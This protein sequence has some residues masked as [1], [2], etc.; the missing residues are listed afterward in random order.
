V[1]SPLAL[2]GAIV[3]ALVVLQPQAASAAWAAAG[4][5]NGPA[6]ATFVHR[7]EAPTATRVGSSVR[8]DWSAVTL[9]EGT[10]VT[11]YTVLRHTGQGGVTEI[12]TTTE[13]TRSC[14]DSAP[15]QGAV[16]YG[17]VARFRSWAGQESP[18]TPFTFDQTPPVT[19]LTSAPAPNA[20]GWNNTAVTITLTATDAASAVASITYRIGT[21]SPVTVTG[22][23][24]SFPVSIE[25][26]TPVTYYATDTAGNVEAARSYTVKIDTAPPPAPTFTAISN[27]SGVLS[28]R[29]TNVAAQTLSGTAE[30]GT[31]V[32]IRR[33]ATTFPTTI[34]AGN[35]TYSVPVT[36]V[37]GVNAFTATAT[38]QAGNNSSAS[39]PFNVTLD[40]VL[41]TLTIT[42]PKNGVAYRNNTGPAAN[43]WANTCS[44]YPGACGTATDTGPGVTSVTLT[45]RD[46]VAN[47]CWSGTGTTYATCGSQLGVTTVGTS[48]W[49]RSITYS[50]VTGRSLQ[51]TI[52]VTD[53]AGNFTSGTVNFTAQ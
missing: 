32:T 53:L 5:G 44:G 9:D 8:L 15:V 36:L 35:G 14:T 25:G 4:T 27:D 41:P 23:S 31:I 40:T 22:S 45:L 16:Q 48:Q 38:D 17:V 24:T 20:A 37:E 19:S 46:T 50:V 21:G 6:A 33:G 49:W 10:A 3:A 51:L 1:R 39:A 43:Q 2:I 7:A 52:T 18:L 13:P 47:T 12:C 29:V 28:D 26:Q 11:G 34:V 42:D 30:P